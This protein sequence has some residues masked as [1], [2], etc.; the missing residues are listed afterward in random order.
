MNI[1]IPHPYTHELNLVDIDHYEFHRILSDMENINLV[2]D[3]DSADFVFFMNDIRLMNPRIHNRFR[4]TWDHDVIAQIKNH[5][6]YHKEVIIDFRDWT[7]IEKSVPSDA[8]PHVHRY[9]KRSIVDKKNMSVINYSRP[10]IPITFALPTHYIEYDITHEFNDGHQYDV[11]C[12]F[13]RSAHWGSSARQWAR[14]VVNNYRG[15]KFVGLINDPKLDASRDNPYGRSR[16]GC[17]NE[18]YYS[19]LKSSKIIVNANPPYRD[20]DIRTWEALLTGNLLLSDE[21][22]LTKIHKYPLV[23]KEHLVIYHSP[24]ELQ[25]LIQ[26]YVEHEDERNEIGQRG[27]EYALAHHRWENR[28]TEVLENL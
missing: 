8:L 10:I 22:I 21:M 18:E 11:C 4:S 12:L 9:F 7:E 15:S 28:V 26:Y 24:E 23:N 14:T 5:K 19:T 2:S 13:N 17:V 16:Y 20:G 27:R 1:C 3:M 25:D 6:N